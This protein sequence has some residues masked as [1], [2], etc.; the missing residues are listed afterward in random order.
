MYGEMVIEFPEGEESVGGGTTEVVEDFSYDPETNR[1]RFATNNWYPENTYA[2][3]LGYIKNRL[4]T[5]FNIN[6]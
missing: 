1:I 3:L 6:V 5:E 4:K 2:E